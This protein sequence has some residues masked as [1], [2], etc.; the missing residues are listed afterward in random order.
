MDQV[1]LESLQGFAQFPLGPQRWNRVHLRL[2]QVGQGYFR[3][4]AIAVALVVS[5]QQ[6]IAGASQAAGGGVEVDK[7]DP[8]AA[9]AQRV[10]RAQSVGDVAAERCFLAQPGNVGH[11]GS[12]VRRLTLPAL[13][14]PLQYGR[15]QGYGCQSPEHRQQAVAAHHRPCQ[16]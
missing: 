9:A 12:R 1:G 6:G 11:Q 15:H 4:A 14:W 3:A 5:V 7:A 16:H 8:M 13:P 2:H 10:S